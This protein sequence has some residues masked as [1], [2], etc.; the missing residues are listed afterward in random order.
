M[1]S[2]KIRVTLVSLV[3][4]TSL[5]AT[6]LPAYGYYGHV[7]PGFD[8][9]KTPAATGYWYASASDDLYSAGYTCWS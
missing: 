6:T 4:A 5:I 2:L 8:Y 1:S 9:T 7:T 3:P